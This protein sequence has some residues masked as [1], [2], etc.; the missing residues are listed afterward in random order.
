[1][2]I[3]IHKPTTPGRRKA[4]VV[5]YSTLTKKRPEKKLIVAKKRKA[6][7]NVRGK[8]TVRH[9]GGEHKKFY[10]LVDNKREKF[11]IPATVLAIEYDPNRTAWLALIQYGDNE[12]RYIIAPAD[13]KVGDQ[14]VASKKE[15]EIKVGNRLPLVRIPVGIMVHDI[16]M[17]PGSKGTLVRSAGSG[18]I[19][20]SV[21]G[22]FA[23]LKLPSGEI[24]IFNKDCLATIGQVSNIDHENVRL[25]KA[26]RKRWLGIRPTVTGKSMNPVDHPHGGGE[27][28]API[29]LKHPKTPWGKP[30]LGVK[31]RKKGKYS[32]KFIIKRRK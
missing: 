8:I 22:D 31:T 30:A 3:K 17:Q 10:R 1:M 19:I 7:R 23:Q 14:I 12:K 32:D 4:S 26:G 15:A 21:E 9:R 13:L 28:H 18:A 6:G 2:P 24:R 5:D 25:G 27:G 29:G 16:E 11:D 20:Q